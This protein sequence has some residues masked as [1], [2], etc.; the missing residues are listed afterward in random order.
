MS[1]VFERYSEKKADLKSIFSNSDL[2]VDY[3]LKALEKLLND[4]KVMKMKCDTDSDLDKLSGLILPELKKKFDERPFLVRCLNELFIRE[5]PRNRSNKFLSS[6]EVYSAPEIEVLLLKRLQGGNAESEYAQSREDIAE[7]FG[8]SKNT[9]DIYIN[10]LKKGATILGSS[11]QIKLRNRSNNYDSTIHPVFLPLNLSEIYFLTAVLPSLLKD[12]AYVDTAEGIANAVHS[13][14]SV[15]AKKIIDPILKKKG[16]EYLIND[17]GLAYK[18]EGYDFI[19]YE[20]SGEK[21]IVE[22]GGETL[23]GHFSHKEYGLFIDDEGNEHKLDPSLI[24]DIIPAE[25]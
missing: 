20:K 16:L 9:L 24:M 17:Y 5:T 2:G 14:L 12:K 13:Q 11:V 23:S 21:C 6:D 25:K 22:H 7:Q 3:T 4:A 19:Y 8:F 10:E 15:Y 18:A 1:T